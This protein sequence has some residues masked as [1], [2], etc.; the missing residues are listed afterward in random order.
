[1]IPAESSI[2][3]GMRAGAFQ[4]GLLS[5]PGVAKQ[6][7]GSFKLVKQPA[8]SYHALMLNGRRGPLDNGKCDSRSAVPSIAT[9]SWNRSLR[10][11]QGD[12]TDHQPGL[13]LLRRRVSVHTG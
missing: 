6:A 1:M 3:A 2:L 12:R 13:Q 4:L 10:R 11:R 7:G 5:D 8:L 9:R